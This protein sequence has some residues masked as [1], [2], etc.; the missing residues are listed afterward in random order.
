VYQM[1]H[2]T[3][4]LERLKSMGFIKFQ[5]THTTRNGGGIYEPD[6]RGLVAQ[7]KIR[8]VNALMIP[9]TTRESVLDARRR[10]DEELRHMQGWTGWENNE[11]QKHESC[12]TWPP[13]TGATEMDPD[14]QVTPVSKK[15]TCPS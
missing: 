1:Q 7:G 11:N 8:K 4:A 13:P 15:S 3:D 14:Q 5:L 6:I 12:Y 2:G 10:F 9:T